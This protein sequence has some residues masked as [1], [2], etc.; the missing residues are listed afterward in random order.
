MTADP[1]PSTA[2]A[3]TESSAVESICRSHRRSPGSATSIVMTSVRYASPLAPDR[4]RGVELVV[5][6]GGGGWRRGDL[7]QVARAGD[8]EG[9]FGGFVLGAAGDAAG[10]DAGCRSWVVDLPGEGD[11]DVASDVGGAGLEEGDGRLQGGAVGNGAGGED[12][13][14]GEARDEACGNASHGSPAVMPLVVVARFLGG[15]R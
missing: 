15:T 5:D 8:R 7:R 3:T 11:G 13:D 4:L 2:T 9:R 12:E 1:P 10:G 14:E 6:V